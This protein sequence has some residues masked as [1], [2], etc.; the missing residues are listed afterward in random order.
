MKAIDRRRFLA[1]GAGIVVPAG[2]GVA[3]FGPF[4]GTP[5]SAGR[6][7]GSGGSI[8]PTLA[9]ADI[10]KF[11]ERLPVLP[12]MPRTRRLRDG[13]DHYEVAQRQFTQQVLPAGLPATRV[14]GYGSANHPGS[15]HYPAATFEAEVGRLERGQHRVIHALP[16]VWSEE[17]NQPMSSRDIGAH[18]VS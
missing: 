12:A 15:F 13:T 3:R 7:A 2:L 4:A 16:P 1:Y 10:P 18:G 14:W 5:A 6:A 9:G 17:V 8:G 11:R